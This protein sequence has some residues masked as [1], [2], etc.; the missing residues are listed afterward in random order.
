MGMKLH[1]HTHAQPCGTTIGVYLTYI[2][3]VLYDQSMVL[4]RATNLLNGSQSV[5]MG[6]GIWA[7]V[8]PLGVWLNATL[9]HQPESD[10][11]EQMVEH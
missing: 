5:S 9:L 1:T 8:S 10:G 2:Q 4:S 6:F 3:T 7:I 11:L